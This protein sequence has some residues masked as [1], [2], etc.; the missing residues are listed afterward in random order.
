MRYII[1]GKYQNGD[2]FANSWDSIE[3][4]AWELSDI[5]RWDTPTTKDDERVLSDTI[6]IETEEL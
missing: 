2:D 4:L 3:G 6:K 5:K 1:T